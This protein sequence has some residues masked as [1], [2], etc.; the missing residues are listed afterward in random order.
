[1]IDKKKNLAP[2]TV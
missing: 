2:I 1:L